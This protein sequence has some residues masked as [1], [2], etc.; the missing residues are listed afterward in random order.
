MED[1]VCGE[2]GASASTPS[3]LPLVSLTPRTHLQQRMTRHA[4]N[5]PLQPLPPTLNDLIRKAVRK[6]LPRQRRD[7]DA[8]SLPLEDVTE[9]LEVRVATSDGRVAE[10]EGWDVG[11]AS[12]EEEK[13][14]EEV[15]ES[16]YR[17]GGALALS[18][19]RTTHP[20]N[21][22][23]IGIHLPPKTVR[24]RVAHLDLQE[25]LRHTIHVLWRLSPGAQALHSSKGRVPHIVVRRETLWHWIAG[26]E[27]T[28]G[29]AVVAA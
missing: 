20:R 4:R 15:S 23:I 19:A 16:R 7:I 11:L 9:V 5:K 8:R 10:P 3:P 22:L 21:N 14:K 17:R 27:L 24:H 26:C 2:R 29:A 18:P 1:P 12:G 28:V 25:V 6:H 13:K